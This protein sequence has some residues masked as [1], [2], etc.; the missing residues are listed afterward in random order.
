MIE[1]RE[2]KIKVR[3]NMKAPVW[4]IISMRGE[5]KDCK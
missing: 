3:E 2:W 5:K 1:M 4:D